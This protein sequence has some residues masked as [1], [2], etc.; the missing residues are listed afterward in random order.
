MSTSR[1]PIA[2]RRWVAAV[3]TATLVLTAACGGD[4]DEG[5]TTTEATAPSETTAPE[6]TGDDGAGTDDDSTDSDEG[7]P[8]GDDIL[9]TLVVDG[10]EVPLS[11]FC[12]Y[13]TDDPSAADVATA[14]L[15]G[16]DDAGDPYG[17]QLGVSGS[18]DR[19]TQVRVALP[20]TTLNAGWEQDGSLSQSNDEGSY[21]VGD[22]R[23]EI[24][25]TADGRTVTVS[26]TC[27]EV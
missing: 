2:R 6:S 11:G 10:T 24:T 3:L 25:V 26:A 7:S 27:D 1:A 18:P 19:R 5:G 15:S 17:L 16:V 12:A 20:D 23:V 8:D 4:D 9:G 22:G 14:Q 21:T 13:R